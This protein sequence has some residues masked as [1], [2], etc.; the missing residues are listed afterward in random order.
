MLREFSTSGRLGRGGF[1][2]RLLIT[3]PLG[4]WAVTAAGQV[5]GAPYDL[6]VV[7]AYLL[8]LVSMW[9]RRLHDRGHSAWWLLAVFV[10]VLGALG[11][12]IE[13]ALRRG[14]PADAAPDYRS[15][16]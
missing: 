1:W 7:V 10:P 16:R 8:A 3:V 14:L 4:L 2:G 15:V 5:P 6:P 13:C 11:L 12:F 9:G